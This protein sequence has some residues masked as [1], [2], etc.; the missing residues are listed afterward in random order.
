MPRAPG[1]GRRASRRGAKPAASAA[2]LLAGVALA[3]L[4]PVLAGAGGE[5][6]A[7]TA[8]ASTPTAP[9]SVP[10]APAS[11]PAAPA[12]TPTAPANTPTA[13]AGTPTTPSS[14]APAPK[15]PPSR[16]R[17]AGCLSHGTTAWFHGP[18]R[19]E[20]A[21]G[22][23]DGPAPD[24]AA[25]VSMLEREHVRATF[26]MIGRQLGPAYRPLLLRE[27]RAG[28]VLGDHT[29]THPDLPVAGGARWQ[30]QRT[31]AEIRSLTGY[32]PCLFR[33]PY[34]AYDSTVLQAAQ[35]LH[36]A[37]VNW[38]VDPRDWSLPGTA[39]I[40]RTVLAEVQPGSIIIS[41]DGGGPRGQTLAAYPR[42]IAA[43]RARGYRIVT[44]PE[45][46]GFPFVYRPCTTRC[47]G[48]GVPRGAL[49]TDAILE[50]AP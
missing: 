26:F 20:V 22:F 46:L 16:Y 49:P 27:L 2:A 23:D 21:I 18:D 28:D 17:I 35:A 38:N 6:G 37:T 39:A 5:A 7:A 14:P 45:L 47:A 40:V 36:L 25:F 11:T 31:L 1:H 24:T 33:P 34:G 32:T 30:L 41:H 12:S 8:P 43:L 42:I 4:P 50:R 29:W 19:R 3:G 15:P 10:T 13:P 9:A 44:I 48:L